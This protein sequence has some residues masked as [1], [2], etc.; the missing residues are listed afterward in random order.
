MHRV[1]CVAEHTSGHTSA[2]SDSS[3]KIAMQVFG[4]TAAR[5]PPSTRSISSRQDP[6]IA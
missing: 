1:G 2:V 5:P 6:T 3:Q 4:R